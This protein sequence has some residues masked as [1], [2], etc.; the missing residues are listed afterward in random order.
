MTSTRLPVSARSDGGGA[1]AAPLSLLLLLLPLH[2]ASAEI[3]LETSPAW[4]STPLSHRATGGAWADIDGD[5]WLDMVVANGNDM[6]RQSVVIYHN[7]GDG[8][9]PLTPTWSSSDVDYHG[10]LDIGDVNGDGLPDVAVAVYIGAGGFSEPGKAKVYLN[11]GAGAFS[12]TPDWTSAVNFYTFSVAFGDADG[13]GDLDLACACGESY[14]GDPERSK[15][16]FN[17]G[18]V[19]ETT[20]SWE[21]IESGYAMDPVWDDVDLDGD[22][23]LVLCGIRGANRLYLNQQ[24]AGG[25]L[26]ETAAWV[27]ADAPEFGNTAALGDWDG[28]GYPELAVAD[29]DQEGGAGLF[30]VYENSGGAFST[31]PVWQSNGSGYGS[32]VSWVDI[33]LDGDFDLAT[34]RW[35]D[36]PRIFENFGDS[37]SAA[38]SWVGGVGC[39]IENMFWGDVDNDYLVSTGVSLATGDG[40]RTYMRLGRTPVR[41]IDAVEVGGAVLP[42]SAYTQHLA[43]G[44]VSLAVPPAAGQA[45]EVRYTFSRDLDL[46]LTSWD[47]NKGNYLYLST[48][49]STGAPEVASVV[50]PIRARPNPVRTSTVF[51]YDGPGASASELT[52]FDVRGREVRSLHRGPLND[53]LHTWEWAARDEAG[54]R[55]AGGVY[56]ARFRV[57]GSVSSL[58]V[59]V[60]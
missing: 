56:F 4:T 47:S 50:S 23:D 59:V 27:S 46:G 10:H 16:F 40:A 41:S 34:G 20:P 36:R 26:P 60:R 54:R 48:A 18:G 51:R 44:W 19:L 55:V 14:Y 33:D 17:A 7:N 35:W 37:L 13:D 43:G 11:N 15:I 28:D 31:L 30:K 6:A 3:P 21:T 32:H 52:L 8:T 49:P 24:T 45:I 53:G 25:G 9:F 58:K 2:P 57:G 38:T 22:Q 1:G 12:S 29:N 5:G 42:A 39:V